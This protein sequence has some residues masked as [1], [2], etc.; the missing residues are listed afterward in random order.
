[1]LSSWEGR[2]Q[3]EQ[4]PASS[5][6]LQSHT[7]ALRC[8]RKI[9]AS[10][11]HSWYPCVSQHELRFFCYQKS[12]R[13]L[14]ESTTGAPPNAEL[15]KRGS[16]SAKSGNK[17][18]LVWKPFWLDWFDYALCLGAILKAQ[19]AHGERNRARVPYSLLMDSWPT[20]GGWVGSGGGLVSNLWHL[21]P[22][23]TVLLHHP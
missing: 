3:D 10:T 2:C 19:L 11:V 22:I 21:N 6:V 18:W 20:H 7:L 9:K 14:S 17:S 12:V 15:G 23:N 5:P 1:M 4:E 8:L 13:E 16:S